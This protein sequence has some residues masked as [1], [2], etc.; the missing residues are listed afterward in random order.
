MAALSADAPGLA[1]RLAPAP[2][3][4]IVLSAIPTLLDSLADLSTGQA[5]RQARTLR[6][7]ELGRSLLVEQADARAAAQEAAEAA[8]A[9]AAAALEAAGAA[10]ASAGA[11]AVLD[12]PDLEALAVESEGDA[13]AVVAAVDAAARAADDALLE[14]AEAALAARTADAAARAAV[15]AVTV[16]AP[17]PCARHR[18]ATPF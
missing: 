11:A 10:G 9:A 8:G 18:R 6:A 16:F 3:A 2:G 5:A 14:A 15:N 13:P 7:A 12:R 1:R 4:R 17:D